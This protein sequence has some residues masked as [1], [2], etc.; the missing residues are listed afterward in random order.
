MRESTLNS[1]RPQA[2]IRKA[3]RYFG[4]SP[5][6]LTLLSLAGLSSCGRQ[7]QTTRSDRPV[8]PIVAVR[9][10]PVE[11][12]LEDASCQS[13]Q[14]NV[15]LT[16]TS[17]PA[18]DGSD[19]VTKSITFKET[20]TG[21]SIESPAVGR[22]IF[23]EELERY[24]AASY[25][26]QRICIGKDGKEEPWTTVSPGRPLRVCQDGRTYGRNSYEGIALTS[27]YYLQHARE[28]YLRASRES[29]GPAPIVLSIMPHVVDYYPT[30]NAKGEPVRVKKYVTHN[31]AYFPDS[32]LIAVFPEGRKRALTDKGFFWESSFALG[33]EYGH[34]IDFSR[35]GGRYRS[36]GLHYIPELHMMSDVLAESQGF[37]SQSRRSLLG[38]ALAEAFA[39]LLAYYADGAS[40]R[41]IAGLPE[42]GP[43]RNVGIARFGNGEAKVLN[44]ERLQVFF[45]ELN[46]ESVPPTSSRYLDIH[47]VG[48]IIAHASDQIFVRLLK[49]HNEPGASTSLD[50]DQ[51]Y[52]LTLDWMDS[53][54][55]AL[56]RLKPESS[57]DELTSVLGKAIEFAATRHLAVFP[58][59]SANDRAETETLELKRDICLTTEVLLPAL[60]GLPYADASGSCPL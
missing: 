44:D 34:H 9:D 40:G 60:S 41:S 52:L 43:N 6:A 36:G 54:T 5:S 13:S 21:A 14:E 24:C 53:V 59:G 58:L 48:A 46:V 50:A 8:L 55:E 12:L 29:T 35:H 56:A 25:G 28:T 33:H 1:Y 45:R 2:L 11:Y 38:G 49:A 39:D 51:R 27:T 20:K 10:E 37:P 18:W 23:Q 19:L 47:M 4:A 7:E 22:T 16:R 42:I 26:S 57:R 17:I 31:L 30:E 3:W 32:T 15:P